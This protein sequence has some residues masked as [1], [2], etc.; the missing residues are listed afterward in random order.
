KKLTQLIIGKP[1]NP[2]D[3]KTRHKIA[4][5]AF[6]AWIGLGADGLSSACYGPAQ[7]FLSLGNHTYLAFYLA[8]AIA[9]SVFI[10]SFAYNQVVELFP[11]GGGGYKVATRLLGSYPGLIA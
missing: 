10:I 8:F 9:I 7:A 6:L 2:L 1:F 11:T 5:S 3:H 4:L